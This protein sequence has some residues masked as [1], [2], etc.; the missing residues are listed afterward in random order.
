MKKPERVGKICAREHVC[1]YCEGTCKC[2]CVGYMYV[3]V[4]CFCVMCEC[5]VSA[6]VC[7]CA[8]V[9][10]SVRGQRLWRPCFPSTLPWTRPLL[11]ACCVRL[12][13]ELLGIPVSIIYCSHLDAE[14]LGLQTRRP[15]SWLLWGFLGF[16]L[17]SFIPGWQ[18]PLA[19]GPS[20]RS[21]FHLPM[22]LQILVSSFY[23]FYKLP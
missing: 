4:W 5:Q 18:L 2:E 19:T 13:L 1:L 3:Y 8:V 9:N 11:F 6:R 15:C 7:K 14:V 12:A 22:L 16:E 17:R 10:H 23:I 20:L 21:T